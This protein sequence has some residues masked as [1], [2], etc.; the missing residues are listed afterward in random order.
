MPA[1]SVIVPIYNAE[2]YLVQCLDSIKN[3]TLEDI[4]IL[5]VND[6]STDNS[7]E[8]MRE[9]ST[10]DNRFIVFDKANGGY[11]HALN[12]G[13][14]HARGEYVAIVEPDDFIEEHMYEDLF[15]F[16]VL[17]SE[18]ADI[19]KGSYFEYYDGR[20][21]MEEQSL[22]P[23]IS[24][25]MRKEPYLFSLND[26]CEV[27]CHHPC[28]WSAIYRK[29]FLD[30][31]G[32]KFV[33][34]KGAGWAD[35]PFLAETLT[36]ADKIVWVPKA[37]YYYRQTNSG[38]SSFLKDYHIPFDR[39]REMREILRKNNVS[40][41]IWAALYL[42]EFDYIFSVI[43]EFGFS[44]SD[45]E[46]QTLIR[47][48][49]EDMDENIVLTHPRLR[50]KD[51]RYYKE[52]LEQV[53][54][55][56]SASESPSVALPVAGVEDIVLSYIVPFGNDAKWI[57]EC[58]DGVL[59]Q[60][61][62]AIEVICVNCGSKDRSAHICQR[63]AERDRRIIVLPNVFT[64]TAGGINEAVTCAK[65]E[66]FF[67]MDPSLSLEGRFFSQVIEES[68]SQTLDVVV[69]DKERRFT[70]DVMRLLH[71]HRAYSGKKD[72]EGFM[73]SSFS[74]Q[75]AAAFLFNFARPQ[76]FSKLYR[77]TFIAEKGFE[78]VDGE[79]VGDAVFGAKALLLAR[80][81]G[82]V[83]AD[84]FRNL[85][86][87][88]DLVP[89]C[90][91]L[92]ERVEEKP[93]VLPEVLGFIDGF[94]D[95]EGLYA[96]T[97]GNLLLESFMW[98][99]LQRR[100]YESIRGYVETF[101]DAVSQ[102]MPPSLRGRDFFDVNLYNDYQ[103]LIC[104]GLEFYLANRCLICERDARYFWNDLG[105]LRA[106]TTM[107]IGLKVSKFAQNVLPDGIVG[108]IRSAIAFAKNR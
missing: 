36:S 99:L 20:D 56:A 39:S 40:K 55:D 25:F 88:V 19:V 3:Q 30:A 74:P 80:S 64:G 61:L 16:S 18:R 7:L 29:S 43:G 2:P 105:A 79:D 95:E 97:T 27:F 4:E 77:K 53:K 86:D 50:Q 68:V 12:Y 85:N 34:P 63:Y 107:K 51:I 22:I 102:A 41:D 73:L 72:G 6:G 67:I 75:E 13:L 108:R 100:S 101:V 87:E 47:E 11:G 31:K 71:M 92:R 89:F 28:I 104:R 26:D 15:A 69:F 91:D 58:L 84:C 1:I 17:G 38:A 48:M 66:Y 93:L 10:A 106:S 52:F 76:C 90:L 46:I 14:S 44:E 33:E 81:I 24:H 70:V 5:C 49:L 59:G 21:G 60:P 54:G 62:A 45:P 94:Q 23:N 82:Y 8:I 37:Y 9:F 57:A 35:N 78:F 32:I 96:Q 103:L 42:R 98:D 83:P 65:G